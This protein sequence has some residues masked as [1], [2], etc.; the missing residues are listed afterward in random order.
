M[1]PQQFGPPEGADRFDPRFDV[2]ARY[3]AASEGPIE[4]HADTRC[5]YRLAFAAIDTAGCPEPLRIGRVGIR[6][7]AGPVR[8]TKTV[9]QQRM[10]PPL[11]FDKHMETGV[12]VGMGRMLLLCE[13]E[14]RVDGD[15]NFKIDT[16]RDEI[17]ATVGLLTAVLD[18]RLAREEILEDVL[19]FDPDGTHGATVDWTRFLRHFYPREINTDDRAS[20]AQLE[21]TDLTHGG[22]ALGTACRYYR[23]GTLEVPPDSVVHF[24]T[25]LKALRRR[26]EKAVGGVERLVAEAG[27]RGPPEVSIRD[28]WKLRNAVVHEGASEHPLLHEGHYLLEALVRGLI[29]YRAGVGTNPTSWPLPVNQAVFPHTPDVGI[30]GDWIAAQTVFHEDGLPP[31]RPAAPPRT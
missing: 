9:I 1:S 17:V 21:G 3:D 20:L 11:V 16:W 15:L 31:A 6:L 18:E 29:R 5:V 26:S 25:A 22:G 19:I 28:L 27:L 7:L 2:N 10:P 13:I 30:P 14:D 8:T 23:K 4:L 24:W 12:A